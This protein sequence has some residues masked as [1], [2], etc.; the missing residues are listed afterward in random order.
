MKPLAILAR[1]DLPLAWLS[2]SRPPPTSLPVSQL[3]E[4]SIKILDLEQRM[5]IISTVLIAKL[6]DNKSLYAIE[7]DSP[8]RYVIFRL[9]SR[10]DL[11]KIYSIAIHSRQTAASRPQSRAGS[12]LTPGD[13]VF[14][15]RIDGPKF[16]KRKKLA[17]EAITSMTRKPSVAATTS[18]DDSSIIPDP[19][20]LVTAADTPMPEAPS[21]PYIPASQ[22]VIKPPPE[23][24]RKEILENIRSQYLENLYLSKASTAYFAKGPLSRARAIYQLDIDSTYDVKELI[25]FLKS[26]IL[27][28]KTLENKYKASE[29]GIVEAIS[30]IEAGDG[31]DAVPEKAPRKKRAPKKIKLGKNGLYT[32]EATLLQQWWENY[33]PAMEVPG[34]SRVSITRSRIT[35]LRIRETQ[36]QMIVI[37]ET[38]QLEKLAPPPEPA[39]AGVLPNAS[40][41]KE[42]KQEQPAPKSKAKK[43]QDL[44]ALVN[45]HVDR[46]SIWQ[47]VSTEL[48]SGAIQS[49]EEVDSSN[50]PAGIT[51]KHA[52]DTLKDFCVEVIVPFFSSKLPDICDSIS[53][54]LGGPRILPTARPPMKKA[55]TIASSTARPGAATR[56]A[57]PQ[58]SEAPMDLERL[59]TEERQRS[60]PASRGPSRAISLMRSATVSGTSGL[61]RE[62]SETPSL[63]R[64]P[65]FETKTRGGVN[66]SQKPREVDMTFSDLLRPIS[67][68][69]EIQNE[70]NNVISAIRKPNRLLAGQSMAEVSEKRKESAAS[71]SRKAK[72]PVRNALFEGVKEGKGVQIQAT[73][74]AGRTR[75][76]M[77]ADSQLP[78]MGLYGGAMRHGH[79][80]EPLPSMIPPSSFSR[81]PSSGSRL[82]GDETG[83][84]EVLKATPAKSRPNLSQQ[85]MDTPTRKPSFSGSSFVQSISATPARAPS[86][87]QSL[88][89]A[90]TFDHC[91]LFDSVADTPARPSSKPSSTPSSARVLFSEQ[92]QKSR[93]AAP[94]SPSPPKRQ[95]SVRDFMGPPSKAG[96]IFETP[97][98]AKATPAKVPATPDVISAPL[99]RLDFGRSIGMA[100]PESPAAVMM[101][102]VVQKAPPSSQPEDIYKTLGWDDD[103]DIL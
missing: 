69:A 38:L 98:K 50:A 92:L 30:K 43:P 22:E 9:G 54:K 8:N 42:K 74:K 62:T 14:V 44:P 103:D 73:P 33:D 10:T 96:S 20:L 11:N 3:Y 26:L 88:N 81:V 59:R 56:R 93:T 85:P 35:E 27:P 19:V 91:A 41:K 21:Q 84:V 55:S 48:S 51:D 15:D 63:S 100:V 94:P 7:Y 28:S 57:A 95:S 79:D 49:V 40:P 17:I 64:V 87:S 2:L 46:L 34:T 18:Q 75:D 66:T 53:K 24:T 1:S 82:V 101:K 23:P 76:A 78:R 83:A 80:F 72:K 32:N 58:I 6:D 97:Q 4:A 86:F 45:I 47:S 60:R 102:E 70:L 5:S 31:I 36:L 13:D 89:A 52:A 37:L 90:P 61:K 65:S 12:I 25:E 16:S 29:G 68:K 77:V 71:Q 39:L 99:K 67:K